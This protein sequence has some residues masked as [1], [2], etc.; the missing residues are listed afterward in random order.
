MCHYHQGKEGIHMN[1]RKSVVKNINIHAVT[2]SSIFQVGDNL[3]VK[4]RS[5]AIAVQ[6]EIPIFLG[7]EGGFSNYPLFSRP[8]PQPV[9]TEDVRMTVMNKSPLIKVEQIEILSIAAS[10]VFQVGSNQRIDT[11][12]RVKHFR[13]LL[14]GEVPRG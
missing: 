4:P 2:L 6:R 7:N 10:S 9:I 12:A 3:V 14:R 8:I 11:E 1:M 13:Q 5:R